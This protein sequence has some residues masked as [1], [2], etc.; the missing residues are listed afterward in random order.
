M[1][2]NYSVIAEV[3]QD[4]PGRAELLSA[5][6]AFV[7]RYRS[8]GS[9]T[10]MTETELCGLTEAWSFL[11]SA[12]SGLFDN[13][14]ERN[15]Y[16]AEFFL[17]DILPGGSAGELDILLTESSKAL[18]MLQQG[19]RPDD[20]ALAKAECLLSDIVRMLSLASGQ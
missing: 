13:R 19:E 2:R 11:D 17:Y 5:A 4:H 7:K 6:H 14:N 10:G 18:R 3:Y 15:F 1:N 9:D 16:A 20:I 8:N 12:N